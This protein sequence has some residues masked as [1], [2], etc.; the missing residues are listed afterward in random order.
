[1][2]VSTGRDVCRAKW[3]FALFGVPSVQAGRAVPSLNSSAPVGRAQENQ[4]LTEELAATQESLRQ[5]NR[6]EPRP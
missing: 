6:S 4:R 1:M 5:V 2:S 3:H